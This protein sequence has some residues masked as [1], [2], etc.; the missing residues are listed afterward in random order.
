M[1][2]VHTYILSLRSED[3]DL[4]AISLLALGMTTVHNAIVG[5]ALATTVVA[6]GALAAVVVGHAAVGPIDGT[7]LHSVVVDAVHGNCKRLVLE[8]DVVRV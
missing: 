3:E 8:L 2:T 6:H 1:V 7:V 4:I 5:C